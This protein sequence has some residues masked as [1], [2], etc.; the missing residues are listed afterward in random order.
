MALDDSIWISCVS[1]QSVGFIVAN[2][3]VNSDNLV[4]EMVPDTILLDEL[5]VTQF[6]SEYVFKERILNYQP[7]Y[8]PEIEFHGLQKVTTYDNPLL[9]DQHIKSLGFA[10]VHPFSFI[11]HNTSKK[12]KEKRKMYRINKSRFRTFEIQQKYNR[13]YVSALTNLNGDELTNFIMYCDFSEEFLFEGSQCQISEA[14]LAKLAEFKKDHDFV[15]H[16]TL[17]RVK[18]IIDKEQYFKNISTISVERKKFPISHFTLFRS[19]LTSKGP[20]YEVISEYKA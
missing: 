12:A 7:E 19:T 15:P 10:L 17:A 9:Q 18:R 20:V 16:L 8:K 5:I 11:Y 4:I 13:D 6:P 14:I 1:Y 3:W 2:E